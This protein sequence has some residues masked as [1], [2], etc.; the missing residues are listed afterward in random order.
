MWA[1]ATQWWYQNGAKRMGWLVRGRQCELS[2]RVDNSGLSIS[3][4]G[5]QRYEYSS[6]ILET[7]EIDGLPARWSI[8]RASE[9]AELAG[10]F[11]LDVRDMKRYLNPALVKVTSKPIVV[12]KYYDSSGVYFSV[13]LPDRRFSEVFEMLKLVIADSNLE[14]RF[15]CDFSFI[16]RGVADHPEVIGYD[17]WLAGRPCI[18]DRLDRFVFE[19][20][21][22][23][24]MQPSQKSADTRTDLPTRGE[25]DAQRVR[26]IYGLSAIGLLAL[27]MVFGAPNWTSAILAFC[28]VLF[29]V[30]TLSL[31]RVK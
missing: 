3:G 16:P 2:F 11:G 28:A 22:A 23:A 30:M 27:S 6:V 5:E 19:L 26:Q 29:C 24:G 9:A 18:L 17:D 10:S 20:H 12:I 14:Y 31:E 1:S 7:R 21:R 13:F 8:W 15:K 4:V 25:N